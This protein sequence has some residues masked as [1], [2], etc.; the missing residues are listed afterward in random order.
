MH[1]KAELIIKGIHRDNCTGYKISPITALSNSMLHQRTSNPPQ[2][3][4]RVYV[5]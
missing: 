5:Y 1:K 2:S 4:Y 3:E